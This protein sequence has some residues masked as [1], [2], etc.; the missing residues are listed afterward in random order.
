MCK[1]I[2]FILGFL[3]VLTI[4]SSAQA[5]G[6]RAWGGLDAFRIK[7][8]QS[9][10]LSSVGDQLAFVVSERNVAKNEDY[11]S[12]WVLPTRGGRPSALTSLE[13]HASSP[14]WSPDAKRIA[15]FDSIGGDLALWVM[16]A[17]GSNKRKLTNLERS[18]AFLGPSGNELSWSPDGK[19]LAFTAA[20]SRP[21][22]S[23]R[24]RKSAMDS[25][26]GSLYERPPIGIQWPSKSAARCR[27]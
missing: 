20:G 19:Q 13:G 2:V 7:D 27:A 26:I 12:I 10:R 14:R 8:I 16:N 9:L 15:Y 25:A 21:A 18:N 17:D 4:L 6:K 5:T 22:F 24:A 3:F 11:S 23:A 1:A